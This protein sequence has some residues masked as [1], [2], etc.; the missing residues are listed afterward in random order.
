MNKGKSDKQCAN[1]VWIGYGWF[2]LKSTDDCYHSL[3]PDNLSTEGVLQTV[4]SST[5]YCVLFG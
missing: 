3:H 2:I 1:A 4:L 5:H